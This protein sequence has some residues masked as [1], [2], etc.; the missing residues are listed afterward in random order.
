MVFFFSVN[1]CRIYN[2]HLKNLRFVEDVLF[3]PRNEL[4]AFPKIQ[5]NG[6]ESAMFILEYSVVLAY[7]KCVAYMK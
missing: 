3:Y 4:I 2:I 6:I 7:K 5:I 1:Y